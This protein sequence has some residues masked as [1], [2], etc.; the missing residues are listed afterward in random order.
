MTYKSDTPQVGD[1]LVSDTGE[2]K[3]TWTVTKVWKGGRRATVRTEDPNYVGPKTRQATQGRFGTWTMG[4]SVVRFSRPSVSVEAPVEVP[5][6]EAVL[7]VE[8]I[9]TADQVAALDLVKPLVDTAVRL[10]RESLHVRASVVERKVDPRKSPL[11]AQ[12]HQRLVGACELLST[13]WRTLGMT[14]QQ[15]DPDKA[16]R[17][18]E[19]W[20]ADSVEKKRQEAEPTPEQL[21]EYVKTYAGNNY[22]NG[23][24]IIVETYSDE[25][26]AAEIAKAQDRTVAGVIEHFRMI[27]DVVTD[28]RADRQP[29]AGWHY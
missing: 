8:P 19:M 10:Y 1:V 7:L 13:M 9:V 24:D 12:A 28:H 14:E 27:V 26:L 23:W 17:I 2:F 21:S 15:M 4:Y 11:V 25:E 5:T 6:C 20:H 16:R 29:V 3:R 18:V 22:D